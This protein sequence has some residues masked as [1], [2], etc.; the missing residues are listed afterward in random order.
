MSFRIR[1]QVQ[2]VGR[3][4]ASIRMNRLSDGTLVTNAEIFADDALNDFEDDCGRLFHL[5]G[6]NKMAQSMH[7]NLRA[8]SRVVIQGRLVNRPRIDNGV[9]YYRTEVCVSEF[10]LLREADRSMQEVCISP[11]STT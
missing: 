6:W 11:N 1:N 8:K 9:R 3:L 7:H 10:M 2:L 5:V 4:G